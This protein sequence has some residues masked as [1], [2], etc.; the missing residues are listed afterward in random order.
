[1]AILCLTLVVIDCLDLLIRK[2]HINTSV[3]LS[4]MTWKSHVLFSKMA[5]V[6]LYQ[7]WIQRRMSKKLQ[8]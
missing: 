4:Q 1:V 8:S 3:I 2:T 6:K 5:G 7:K